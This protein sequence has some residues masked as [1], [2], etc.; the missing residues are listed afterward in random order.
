MENVGRQQ[1]EGNQGSDKAKKKRWGLSQAAARKN[2]T[3]GAEQ[4][5]MTGLVEIISDIL[6]GL[7]DR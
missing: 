5:K 3:R 4:K 6:Q 2:P 7:Q 1:P